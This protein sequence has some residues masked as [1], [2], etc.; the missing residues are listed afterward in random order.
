MAEAFGLQFSDGFAMPP[1]HNGPLIFS[2]DDESLGVH[3]IT[4][5]RGDDDAVRV[6]ASFTGSAFLAGPGLTPLLTL[7]PTTLSYLPQQAGQFDAGMPR[8][9]VSGWLQGAAGPIG[10]GRLVVFGEAA[11]FTAQ[12][13][14]I[15][16]EIQGIGFVEPE[17]QDNQQLLLNVCRWLAGAG[18]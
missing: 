17:A 7:P 1:G 4:L 3:A 12:E 13:V 15:D 14:M 2:R 6:V 10:D 11:M 8:A 18:D 9:N 16:G 5:G